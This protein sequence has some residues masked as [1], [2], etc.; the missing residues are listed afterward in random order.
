[1][2]IKN[3]RQALENTLKNIVDI[4]VIAWENIVYKPINSHSFIKSRVVIVS[5]EKP[6]VGTNV[7]QGRMNGVYFI[8]VFTAKNIGPMLGDSI[9]EKILKAFFPGVY[10][11]TPDGRLHIS[12]NT[13]AVNIEEDTWFHIPI[14]VEWYCYYIQSP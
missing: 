8:D 13:I 6:V 3:V 11:D 2:S 1:M 14:T 5:N 12:T 10:L 4:P 9:S 7:K